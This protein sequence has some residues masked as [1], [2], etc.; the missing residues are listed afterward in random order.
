MAMDASIECDARVE[1]YQGYSRRAWAWQATCGPPASISG[2]RERHKDL[3]PLDTGQ[4]QT[5][6]SKV[7]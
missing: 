1:L 3:Q 6:S 5:R 4:C 2:S 7:A